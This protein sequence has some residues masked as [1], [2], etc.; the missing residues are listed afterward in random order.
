MSTQE[1]QEYKDYVKQL[2]VFSSCIQGSILDLIDRKTFNQTTTP[3]DLNNIC[4]EERAKL[5]EFTA[6]LDKKA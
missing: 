4:V 5:K 2:E 6:K 1:S 3:T